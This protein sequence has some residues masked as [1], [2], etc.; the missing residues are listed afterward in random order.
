MKKY[1]IFAGIVLLLDSCIPQQEPQSM[2]GYRPVYL[3]FEAMRQ[4]EIQPP[5]PMK[6][7]GKIYIKDNY[8][9]VNEPNKGIHIINNSN[10]EIPKKVAFL[11]IPASVDM[12]AKGT[13]L[14]VDNGTDLVVLDITNPEKVQLIKRVEKVFTTQLFPPEVG[15]YFECV[16]PTKG[17]VVGW[18]KVTFSQKPICRR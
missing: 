2:T 7:A 15:V 1:I 14:Y 12:A 8:L 3:S 18:D 6:Q 4:I 13:F 9:F 16:D 10:P 5:Q 17:V 11:K